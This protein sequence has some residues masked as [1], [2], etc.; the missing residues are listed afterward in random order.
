MTAADELTPVHVLF[1]LIGAALHLV[2]GFFVAAS[3]LVAPPWGVAIL[4]VVWVIGAVVALRRWRS[5]MFVPLIVA[6][7]TAVFWIGLVAFGG[8]VLGWNA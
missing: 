7:A 2:V 5:S 1:V 8:A 3:G 4:V 6:C